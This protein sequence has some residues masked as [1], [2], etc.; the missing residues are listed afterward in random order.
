MTTAPVPGTYKLLRGSRLKN[1]P[2]IVVSKVTPISEVPDA[3]Q[4]DKYHGWFQI[5]Y[6]FVPERPGDRPI[7]DQVDKLWFILPEHLGPVQ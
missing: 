7:E 6:R 3:P 2:T 4:A 1:A 5:R